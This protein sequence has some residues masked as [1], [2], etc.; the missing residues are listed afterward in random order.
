MTRYYVVLAVL[1]LAV[2]ALLQAFS[3]SHAPLQE[4]AVTIG[5]LLIGV[6]GSL[7]VSR[8]QTDRGRE[9]VE[10]ALKD[11]GPEFIITDWAE[12][13]GP[14]AAPDYLVVAPAGVAA[15]VTDP[16]PQ[17]TWRRLVPRRLAQARARGVARA[18]WAAEAAAGLSLPAL[19]PVVVLTRRVVSPDD[20]VA[21]EVA[22]VN[23]E[24]LAD[25]LR[26]LAAP[27]RLTQEE[28]LRITRHLR[29]VAEQQTSGGRR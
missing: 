6:V 7:A 2:G 3:R 5:V 28:R 16:M 22:V 26:Q 4:M 27:E 21:G 9:R 20:E 15:V 8:F 23:A 19:V 25:Q 10:Q 14:A 1:A 11:L 13:R 17:S 18:A 24:Q 12:G 29:R